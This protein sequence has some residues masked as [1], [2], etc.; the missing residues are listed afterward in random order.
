M[1]ISNKSY[2]SDIDGLRAFAILFVVAYHL[3]PKT[4]TGG[5]IGVL[6]QEEYKDLV[7]GPVLLTQ[8]HVFKMSNGLKPKFVRLFTNKY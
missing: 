1:T 7:F 5:Y 8:I 2:R 4:F 3:W 6:L